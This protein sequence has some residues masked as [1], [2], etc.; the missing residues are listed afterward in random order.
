MG[1]VSIAPLTWIVTTMNQSKIDHSFKYM[2]NHLLINQK[3][4][5]ERLRSIKKW[6]FISNVFRRMKKIK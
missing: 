3:M 1:M 4:M 6:N 2:I 5:E